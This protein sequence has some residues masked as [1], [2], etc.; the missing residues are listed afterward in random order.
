M[1]LRHAEYLVTLTSRLNIPFIFKSSYDKANR[2]SSRSFRGPGLDDGLEILARVK[3]QFGVAVL[4]DAHSVPEIK[5]AGE[6]VDVLQIPAFLCR[7]TDLLE[8]A[9]RTGRTVNVKKGQW[10]AP[11]DVRFIIEKLT[12]AGG[13]R[14]IITERGSTFGYHQLVVDFT[15][16]VK[17]RGI[18]WPVVFDATHSVQTPGSG[19]GSTGGDRR[20]A[21]YLAAAAAAVGVDGLFVETH[22]DPDR[23]LS[24]GPNMIP[25]AILENTIRKFYAISKISSQDCEN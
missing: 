17:M 22:E 6:V 5:A 1:I 16:I 18:G 21:P 20:L 25:L 12:N 10:L 2:T 14:V 13:G 8:A 23:A 19:N 24:D 9:A 4:T 7:Q 3:R 15:G 11:D